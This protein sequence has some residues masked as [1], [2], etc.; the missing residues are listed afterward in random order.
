[1]HELVIE[2][3]INNDRKTKFGFILTILYLVIEY[4]RPMDIIPGLGSIRPAMILSILLVVTWIINGNISKA[5]S[6]QT[7]M[8]VIFILLLSLYIPFAR[9][10]YFAFKQTL[11]VLLYMPF[12]VSAIMYINSFK[13]LRTFINVWIL[14]MIYLSVMGIL[15]K[16]IGGSNFLQ[17]END[18]SLL[19][20]MM[21]PFVFFLFMYEKSIKKKLVYLTV[22][23]L[24]IVSIVISFSRGGFVTLLAVLLIIWLFSPK[25]ILS[26]III[27]ILAVAVN[28]SADQKYWASISTIEKTE[29]GTAKER[30]D[31]WKAAWDM[32]K[33]NPLGVG[34][35]NFPVRFPDYQPESMKRGM[36][37]RAAHSIWFTLISEL[38][39]PGILV[40]SFLLF[41]NLRDI[42]WLRKFKENQ[43]ADIRYAYYLSLAFIASFTGYFTSGTFLS[44]LY[45]PHYFYLTAIIVSI[46]KMSDSKLACDPC[47]YDN[48][49]G[50]DILM[51]TPNI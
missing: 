29:E 10:N 3:R 40:Y 51:D 44:V 1:M 19:M 33:D 4:G 35:G 39:I 26:L 9:N 42:N 34:G 50:T 5:K 21:F 47:L 38:G 14:L 22:S 8:M 36:W 16:G 43:D 24:A 30:L 2:N 13:R 6:K 31:S 11:G 25:K 20:N 41:Y 49:A 48:S 32:F 15:N 37:G 27:G 23:I 46:K 45:Y 12:F 7:T 28:Y 17:D 18:F